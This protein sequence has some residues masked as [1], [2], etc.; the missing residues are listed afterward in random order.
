MT[1]ASSR[2]TVE[3]LRE[4]FDCRDGALYWRER[5]ESH[6]Q[7]KADQMAFNT[8]SAGKKAGKLS[9]E[10]YVQLG[11]RVNGDAISMAGH[12]VVWALHYGKWP[13]K[14]LDHINRFRTDNRIENLR[15]VTPVENNRNASSNRVFP[16]V[17]PNKSCPGTFCAQTNIGGQKTVHLGVFDTEAEAAAHRDMVNAELEKLARS[18]AKKSKTG[19]KRKDH[20][21]FSQEVL[22][23]SRE[24]GE[25]E[26]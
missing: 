5:P 6:F 8:K 2:P 3:F 25:G 26:K 21:T 14:H 16:Y 4:C 15:E 23:P 17:A 1:K 12:R 7:K 11:L 19:R 24:K 13:D 22:P 20:Q 10:G 9:A 18:L